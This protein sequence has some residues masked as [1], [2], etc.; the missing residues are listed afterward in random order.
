MPLRLPQ[1]AFALMIC[2]LCALPAPALASV[3]PTSTFERAFGAAKL[4]VC[5]SSCSSASQGVGAAQM[6]SPYGLT[7]AD[8]EAYATDSQRRVIVWDASTG[9]FKRVL[10]KDVGGAG[11]GVCTYDTG[12]CAAPTSGS[13]DGQFNGTGTP[14]VSAGEIFIPDGGNNRV[15]VLDAATG[16]FKRKFGSAGSGGAG[17][18]FLPNAVAISGNEL[19]VLDTGY[20]RVDVFDA[21]TGQF[22]RAFGKNVGG[23]GVGTCTSPCV[24]GTS[25]SSAGAIASANFLN[26]SAG[27]VFVSEY[28]NRRVSVFN[29]ASG[30]FQRAIGADVGGAGINVCSATCI[31]GTSG[32]SGGR[33]GNAQGV[34]VI[35]ADVF[36]ADPNDN[37]IT[38]YDKT[39]GTFQRTI[40]PTGTGA[41]G[42]SAT[43]TELFMIN[44]ST[45]RLDVFN[46]A[47]GAFKRGSSRRVGAVAPFV[48]T[49]TTGGCYAGETP[50]GGVAPAGQ[51]YQV[52]G[53]A[54][55]G[56]ELFVSEGGSGN[57]RVSV[58]DEATGAFKRA[59][60]AAVNSSTG[61][62][63]C[64]TSS[65]CKIVSTGAAAGQTLQPS[66]VALSGGELF[67]ADQGNHRVVV[68]DP[69]DGT[70][71]RALGRNVNNAGGTS[72]TST[73]VAG[74]TTANLGGINTPRGIAISGGELYVSDGG[75]RRVV[76]MDPATGAFKRAIG[77]NV[78]P[79]ANVC[80]VACAAGSS[81]GI[82]DGRGLAVSGGE[83]FVADAGGS[84]IDVYNTTTG[85]YRTITAGSPVA[86]AVV[87]GN[88]FATNSAHAVDVRNAQT[89]A[90]L[91]SFGS[92]GS[93]S[94][95]FNTPSA[96]AIDGTRVFV[97]DQ[98]N[99]RVASFTVIDA[100]APTTTDDV[101]AYASGPRPVTLTAS[102]GQ[103]GV[104]KTYFEKGTDPAD[105]TTAS[106]QYDPSSKPTL[107]VG[108]KIKY[109]SVDTVGNTEAV[110]SSATL[111]LDDTPPTTSDNV[112]AYSK[113]SPVTVTLSATDA[114]SGVEGTYYTKGANPPAPTTGD[115][116]YSTSSKPTLLDGERIRY[117]SVD[118]AGN[119]ETEHASNPLVIDDQVPIVGD[120][121]LGY[122]TGSS[123]VPVT[124]TATDPGPSG[125][126]SVLYL[127]GPN[128][129]DP[130]NA[131]NNPLTYDAL[132]RPQLADGEQ[133]RYVATDNAGNRSAVRTSRTM[134]LHAGAT[135]YYATSTLPN[136]WAGQIV[137]SDLNGDG[138]DDAVALGADGHAVNVYLRE[139]GNTGFAA[140]QR[141][142]QT[143]GGF[144]CFANA[145]GIAVGDVTGD[146]RPDI[147]VA[148]ALG[149]GS[150]AVYV[151][152]NFVGGWGS[153]RRLLA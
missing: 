84:R 123:P 28:N 119:A 141:I 148:D 121:V 31:A 105:P 86:V 46:P 45:V 48:C 65:G 67:I 115:S 134:R 143:C 144:T 108:E 33:L 153:P 62:T 53:A 76:V 129:A 138:R 54:V 40:T 130:S 100:T 80:T 66:G 145:A 27:E 102:D 39:L 5:F 140:P 97:G 95:K 70:F 47:T 1:C 101:P 136:E 149:G 110:R 4:D 128:P 109:F 52:T 122:R 142:D 85:T 35:G 94:G 104:D 146:G 21:T 7:T 131:A 38:V 23:V 6:A 9:A 106:A 96:L 125:L 118:K 79:G 89:G 139:A 75:N 88:V 92:L 90:L 98:A 11:I 34:A 26:I 41:A 2:V 147:V 69:Q 73:C 77:T 61:G 50:T 36:V 114:A 58:F 18:L 30:A 113:A 59:L 103:S 55:S 81:T 112:P 71:K 17:S 20:N 13:G 91:Y 19:F 126:A 127:A 124:L 68:I 49:P 64:T 15:Q 137:L 37:H 12:G 111:Q 43:A 87:D 99:Y 42:L 83:V 135:N 107:A 25:G 120:D 24:A 29:A 132:N 133:I 63:S 117:F 151:M 44:A 82:L 8:G 16:A 152:Q 150:G 3:E 51:V 72:C 10:G 22:Q 74:S 14:A 78:Q 116:V 93:T 56:G 32:S 60:G 57:N